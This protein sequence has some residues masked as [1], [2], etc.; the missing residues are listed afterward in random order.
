MVQKYKFGERQYGST[1]GRGPAK[2]KTHEHSST[3]KPARNILQ[4]PYIYRNMYA[5][6]R[7]VSPLC[8]FFDLDYFRLL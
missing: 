2:E 4:S 6:N 5:H 1:N 7:A 3:I 8:V